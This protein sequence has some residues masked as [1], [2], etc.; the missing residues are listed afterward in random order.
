[1]HQLDREVRASKIPLRREERS[2]IK[3]PHKIKVQIGKCSNRN[4]G[5]PLSYRKATKTIRMEQEMENRRGLLVALFVVR[6]DM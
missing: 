3:V 1:M 2:M 4:S 6:R 5:L